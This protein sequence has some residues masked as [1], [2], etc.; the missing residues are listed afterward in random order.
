MTK[1]LYTCLLILLIAFPAFGAD[2]VISATE[3]ASSEAGMSAAVEA[4]TG[5]DQPSVSQEIL[6]GLIGA[7]NLGQGASPANTDEG[8]SNPE[9]E[10]GSCGWDAATKKISCGKP[11]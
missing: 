3:G 9:Y 6:E 4:L 2:A 1:L 7:E 8:P 11:E 5:G 10:E